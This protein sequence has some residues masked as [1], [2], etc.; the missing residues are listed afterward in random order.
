MTGSYLNIYDVS[1]IKCNEML[2]M[3]LLETIT[4]VALKSM[5][6]CAPSAEK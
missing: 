6:L 2:E 5:W 4:F 1:H 3:L